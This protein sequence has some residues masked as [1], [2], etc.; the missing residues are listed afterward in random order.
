MSEAPERIFLVLDSEYEWFCLPEDVGPEGVESVEYVRADLAKF[1][2]PVSAKAWS[3]LV[4]ECG[5][6]YGN[7]WGFGMSSPCQHIS[8]RGKRDCD[9][10][11]FRP[12]EILG[13]A[14]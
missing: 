14:D 6:V 2:K 4:C 1:D 12:A 11:S 5:H 7:H 3:Q 9:C 13:N 8:A 10:R